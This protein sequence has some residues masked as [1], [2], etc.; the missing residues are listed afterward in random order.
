M[1]QREQNTKKREHIQKKIFLIVFQTNILSSNSFN[2]KKGAKCS[3]H[4]STMCIKEKSNE[5]T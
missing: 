1:N 4:G 5:K 2:K 3:V